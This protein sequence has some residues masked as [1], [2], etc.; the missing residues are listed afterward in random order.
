M[1]FN[2][3][4]F[5]LRLGLRC[6][7][8]SSSYLNKMLFAFL[9]HICPMSSD[10][11]TLLGGIILTIFREQYKLGSSSSC[12]FFHL[13]ISSS[14]LGPNN[15]L[16]NLFSGFSNYRSGGREVCG[17]GLKRSYTGSRVRIPLRAWMF[18]LSFPNWYRKII[19][20]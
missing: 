18:V 9:L 16:R 20:K 2:I 11:L 13:P 7:I 12:S 6:E 19:I 4:S 10:H 15:L 17:E 8:F 14:V 5:P 1:L 3:I